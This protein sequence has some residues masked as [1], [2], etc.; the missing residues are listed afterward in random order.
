MS[1]NKKYYYLKLKDRFYDED[2]IKILQSMPDG[3]LF[4]DILMKLYLKSLKNNGKLMFKEHIPYSPNMIA[5]VTNHNLSVVEKALNVFNELGL[6]EILES[7]EIYMTDIQNFIGKSSTEAD[8]KRIYRQEIDN[9]KLLKGQMSGQMSDKNPP[10]KEKEKEKEIDK[11]KEKETDGDS[12]FNL[13]IYLEQHGFIVQSPNAFMKYQEDINI[14]SLEEVKSAIEIADDR[15]IH[16]YS[17]VKGILE[18]RRSS[19]DS[20]EESKEKVSRFMEGLNVE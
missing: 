19:I 4:S 10:E 3:Y 6:I 5:T 1:D 7:G 15:G 8:R 13:M 20:V 14:Y 11:E 9:K 2:E 18:K 12:S 17:Y 16:N